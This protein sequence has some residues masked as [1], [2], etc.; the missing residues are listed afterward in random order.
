MFCTCVGQGAS[1]YHGSCVEVRAVQ[2]C[3]N[4]FFWEI[5]LKFAFINHTCTQPVPKL[6]V[7]L[8]IMY[9]YSFCLH[10]VY[11]T[12]SEPADPWENVVIHLT[13]LWTCNAFHSHKLNW[14][15]SLSWTM[16][17]VSSLWLSHGPDSK[18][19]LCGWDVMS[20]S[21]PCPR[22]SETLKAVSSHPTYVGT[23]VYSSVIISGCTLCAFLGQQGQK[24]VFSLMSP[25]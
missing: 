25:L 15:H 9:T 6:V 12:W 10:S 11:S 4:F 1:E 2:E 17:P 20:R 18:Q 7:C 23:Y 21:W 22:S 8:E 14:R 3:E 5:C 13:L 19:C 24:K 16:F